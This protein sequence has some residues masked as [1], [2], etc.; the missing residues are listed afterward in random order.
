MDGL[1]LHVHERG[2]D[3]GRQIVVAVD[4]LLEVAEQAP[5]LLRWR[6]NKD[7]I[8][9]A[10]ASDPVL[11]A[12][13]L[14]R[15]LMQFTLLGSW[16]PWDLLACIFVAAAPGCTTHIAAYERP[17]PP[18]VADRLNV[19]SQGDANEAKRTLPPDALQLNSRLSP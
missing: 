1:E 7:G 3:D 19:E 16:G 15:L 4:V 14:A 17:V 6:R 2:A 13:H 11:A 8:A 10:G 5:D 12:A 9:R 18:D